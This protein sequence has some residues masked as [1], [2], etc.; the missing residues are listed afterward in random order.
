MKTQIVCSKLSWGFL[1]LHKHNVTWNFAFQSN[2]DRP[3]VFVK[4][5]LLKCMTVCCHLVGLLKLITCSSQMYTLI[6]TALQ[7]FCSLLSFVSLQF[8]IQQIC[9]V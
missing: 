7:E 2:H 4:T 9:Y 1:T 3:E 6:K 8:A 5:V